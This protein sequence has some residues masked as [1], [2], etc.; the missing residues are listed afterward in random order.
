MNESCY[1]KVLQKNTTTLRC[2]HCQSFVSPLINAQTSTDMWTMWT[3]G[4][5]RY[6]YILHRWLSSGVSISVFLDFLAPFVFSP[7]LQKTLQFGEQQ[8][9]RI[10][11]TFLAN[12]AYPLLRPSD[13][14]FV[15]LRTC[16]N[17]REP[18][19]ARHFLWAAVSATSSRKQRYHQ[20]WR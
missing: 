8:N 5:A 7:K 17:A 14:S 20:Y 19:H 6:K 13:F 2:K 15:S 10:P 12:A 16:T 11:M 4:K 18:Q 9:P 1:G 3:Q